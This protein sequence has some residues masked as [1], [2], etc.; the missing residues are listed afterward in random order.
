[1]IKKL[2][3]SLAVAPALIFAVAAVT[4][5]TATAGPPTQGYTEAVYYLELEGPDDILTFEIEKAQGAG[6]LTV[7]T[8][9]CCILGDLWMVDIDPMQPAAANKN[10][11]GLGDGTTLW[12][13]GAVSMPFVRGLVTVSYDSGVDVFP[14]HLYIRFVY[15]KSTGMHIVAPAGA[16]LVSFLPLP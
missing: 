15:S 13:G 2:L 14:A 5:G 12:S 4:S 7:D 9:D 8:Q 10:G 1:M 6:Q 16:S 11:A 3:S